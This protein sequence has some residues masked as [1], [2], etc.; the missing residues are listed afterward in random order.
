MNIEPDILTVIE[1]C[2]TDG[3][4][5]TMPQLDR[6]TYMR[7]NKIL[8][9]AGGRWNKKA[10][11]HIFEGDAQARIEDMLLTGKVDIPKDEFNFFETPDDIVQ[12]MVIKADIRGTDR[13][14]EPSA[15]M[16]AIIRA[17]AEKTS[18]IDTYELMEKNYNYLCHNFADRVN[19]FLRDFLTVVPEV[20]Y[21]K[22]VMNPPFMKQSDII[23]VSHAWKFVKPTGRLV[24]IMSPGFTFRQNKLS[25]DFLKM[26][27]EF[28]YYEKLPENSF[29][30][31]GT[32][33]STV[34]VVLD[35]P[36]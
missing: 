24:A 36:E 33:V 27:E 22:I 15:G 17:L 18:K 16:G 2:S 31:S 9:A 12:R 26:V 30:S 23:H 11:A 4:S 34:M 25:T 14:L 1:S 3:N 35:K 28:G 29:K 19:V 32:G 8:E 20:V 6:N 13:V 7:V 21:D 5:L 10:K